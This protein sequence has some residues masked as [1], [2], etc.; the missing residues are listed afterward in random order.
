[1]PNMTAE[2]VVSIVNGVLD[3]VARH[4]ASGSTQPLTDAEVLAQLNLDIQNGETDIAQE[5]KTKGWTLPQ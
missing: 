5:F 4:V 3:I 2:M 1:M